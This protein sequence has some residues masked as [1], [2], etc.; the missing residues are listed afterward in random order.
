MARKRKLTIEN[1]VGK[2]SLEEAQSIIIKN[3]KIE[4]LSSETV[5]K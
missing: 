4:G 1:E 3:K 5:R 2:V